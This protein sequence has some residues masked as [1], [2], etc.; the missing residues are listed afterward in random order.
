MTQTKNCPVCKMTVS[1]DS[2]TVTHRGIIFWLC[3]EQCRDRFNLRPSL[4]IGD[5]KQGKSAKQHGI[6]VHKKRNLNLELP[7][8]NESASLLVQALNSLMGVTE[9][10]INQGQL[11]IEYDLVEVS[12]EEIEAFIKS[13]G[14]H[15]E[16]SWLDKIHDSFI[17]YNE[18]GQ[19]GNLGHPYKDN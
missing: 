7:N 1:E 2:Y 6:K 18:E 8:N 13:T 17:H 3:S 5:P 16:Q 14:I 19:L 15:I 12:L 11:E 4:Y 9:A 10:K